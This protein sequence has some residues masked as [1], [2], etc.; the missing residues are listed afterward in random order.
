MKHQFYHSSLIIKSILPLLI[1]A[2]TPF[3]PATG[4]LVVIGLYQWLGCNI[5]I[6]AA[7]NGQRMRVIL[8]FGRAFE[9]CD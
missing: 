2:D 6:E 8:I 1:V 9:L 7:S 3:I 5:H 4:A